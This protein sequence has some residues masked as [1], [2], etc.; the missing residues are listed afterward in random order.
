MGLRQALFA[1]IQ[2]IKLGKGGE[3]GKKL[4]NLSI[5]NFRVDTAINQDQYIGLRHYL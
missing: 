3:G 1:V 4:T 5:N 2:G